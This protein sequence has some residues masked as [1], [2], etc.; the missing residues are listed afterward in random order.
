MLFDYIQNSKILG[1]LVHKAGSL[2]AKR[3]VR[4]IESFLD[5]KDTILDI[6]C[7]TCNTCEV[8]RK[9]G[10]A[11]TPLDVQNRSFVRGIKPILYDGKKLPFADNA[12]DVSII[13]TVLHHASNPENLLKEAKRVAKKVIIIEDIYTNKIHKYLTYFFDSLLNLQFSGHPHTNKT[14]REWKKTFHTLGMKLHDATYKN[15][16]LVFKHA[17]YYLEA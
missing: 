8:L 1:K 9:K 17:K 15:S 7:G 10:Y 14:D 2:R 3:M 11:I 4:R 13:L 16:M 6:G 5:K 12:F